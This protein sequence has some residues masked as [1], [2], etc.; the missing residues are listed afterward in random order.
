[1]AFGFLSPLL[2]L[3]FALERH[4][5]DFVLLLVAVGSFP[6]ILL[7]FR[8]WRRWLYPD[9]L[10]NRWLEDSL[11]YR[12]VKVA[13]LIASG[14][15]VVAWLAVGLITTAQGT[16]HDKARLAWLAAILSGSI[17]MLLMQYREDR[18]P[19]P[20]LVA[21]PSISPYNPALRLTN[22]IK[23]VYSKDW[24]RFAGQ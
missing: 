7:G 12:W 22:T 15:N 14:V 10:P 9:R 21:L 17:R 5:A 24:D 3:V 8:S 11:A 19:L 4:V 18:K 20:P 2:L 13:E 1:M 23:P 16:L 6:I